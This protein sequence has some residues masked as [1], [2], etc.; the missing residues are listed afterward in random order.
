MRCN[1][2]SGSQWRKHPDVWPNGHQV[3]G[4]KSKKNRLESRAVIKGYDE[5]HPRMPLCL[6]LPRQSGAAA[7]ETARS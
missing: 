5:R 3:S 4:A 7:I 6:M 2:H 1:E